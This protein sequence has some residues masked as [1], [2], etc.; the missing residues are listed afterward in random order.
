MVGA[1]AA[2]DGLVVVVADRVVLGQVAQD[3][4]VTVGHV[5][6]AHLQCALEDG[7]RRMRAVVIAG[8]V[9][10]PYVEL[11]AMARL[12]VHLVEAVQWVADEGAVELAAAGVLQVAV[13]V[14]HVPGDLVR[15][16]GQVGREP[17]VRDVL[18]LPVAAGGYVGG[19]GP[20]QRLV[21]AG[22]LGA[23][24]VLLGIRG[25]ELGCLPPV[26]PRAAAARDDALGQQ[27]PDVLALGRLVGRVD[28]VEA[29][30]LADD[31]DDVLDRR[32]CAERAAVRR[33]GCG[34]ACG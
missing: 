29:V 21:G 2:L 25:R 5:V 26:G 34:T 14:G 10:R 1:G 7:R 23:D 24:G 9:G 20:R 28:V 15:R 4:R 6:V 31:H 17:L 12:L 30:V 13:E 32:A 33:G 22:D 11:P 3:G 16:V 19:V 27:V 8:G 18:L